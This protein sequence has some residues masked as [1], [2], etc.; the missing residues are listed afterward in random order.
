MNY[1]VEH[2]RN[3]YIMLNIVSIYMNAA[4]RIPVTERVWEELSAL[5]MAGQ[6]YDELLD[7]LIEEHK[8]AVLFREMRAIEE[9]DAF[10]ELE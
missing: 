7:D 3:V 8:K 2:N 1:F 9:K 6:T 4:K 10:V 5:K